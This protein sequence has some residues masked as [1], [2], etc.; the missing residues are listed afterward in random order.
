MR[1][2]IYGAGAIG[3][4]LGAHLA[5]AGHQ[6]TLLGREPLVQ[7]VEADGLLLSTPQGQHRIREIR[8]VNNI[9]AA[10]DGDTVYDWIA[11]TMKSYDTVS[12]IFE[13]HEHLPEP[14]P[15]ACFQN[16]I[17]NEESLRDAFGTDKVVAA[18]VT[19]AISMQQPG[20]VIEERRRGVAIASDLPASA[21]V[22][23]AFRGTGLHVAMIP[24]PAALKWSK[25]LTNLVANAVCAILDMPPDKVL[26]DPRLFR[27]EQAALREAL[28]I[29]RLKGIPVIDLP[30]A[31]VR[32]LAVAAQ[33]LPTVMLHPLLWRWLAA[34]RGGKAPSLLAALR[35]GKRRT[36]VAWINGGVVQAAQSINFLAPVN[37]AL[38]LLVSDIVA[39]R[40]VWEAYR[41]K[42]DMLITSIRAVKGM[43]MNAGP[44]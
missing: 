34:G 7:A 22:G 29:M 25:L 44:Q 5:L 32:A 41:G 42:P 20:T 37:H 9:E 33:R 40:V 24:N 31:P 4:Y 1:I 6:V 36:E 15:I 16:G 38:A 27:I 3:S 26:R 12:A 19:T 23:S 14:P 17:G 21:R 30:Q 10:L 8:A 2:L 28:V 13:L 43:R 11:F 18:A 39:G 35:A